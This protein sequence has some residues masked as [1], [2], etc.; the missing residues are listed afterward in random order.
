[1]KFVIYDGCALRIVWK[2]GGAAF[3]FSH[4]EG[5]CLKVVMAS[6]WISDSLFWTGV[7]IMSLSL[8]FNHGEGGGE[9]CGD[10]FTSPCCRKWNMEG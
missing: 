10:G 6:P 5:D 1:M 3:E 4:G 8:G 7:L 2:I 9:V